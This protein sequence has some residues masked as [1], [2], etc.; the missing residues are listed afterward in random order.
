MG[1]E[2][3]VK[4]EKRGLYITTYATSTHNMRHKHEKLHKTKKRRVR[5]HGEMREGNV[6]VH[7]DAKEKEAGPREWSTSEDKQAPKITNATR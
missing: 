5:E 2:K 3:G 7:K 1:G 4:K 6:W